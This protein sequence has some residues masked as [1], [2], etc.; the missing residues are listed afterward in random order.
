M[1]K[2]RSK[3]H[4]SKRPQKRSKPSKEKEKT[5]FDFV[6]KHDYVI[7]GDFLYVRPYVFEFKCFFKPRWRDRTIFEVFVDEFRYADREY[8]HA[9]FRDGRILRNGVVIGEDAIW[10][11]S[12]EVL[13]LVHRHESAVLSR[14]IQVAVDRDDFVVVSK[15]PSMPVH[16]CG[17]YRRNSLQFILNAFHGYGRLQCIHRLDKETSGLVILA[18]T[19]EAA[20]QF[21]ESMKAGKVRKTYLAEVHGTFPS[22]GRHCTTPILWDKREMRAMPHDDGLHAETTFKIVSS[23]EQR[24]TSIV[25]C[26][27][28]TGRTHQLRVHLAHLG[29]PIVND[30]IYGNEQSEKEERGNSWYTPCKSLELSNITL[31][32][33]E[34]DDSAVDICARPTTKL[35]EWSEKMERDH[36]RKLTSVEEGKLLKCS[37][38]PQVTNIK[39]VSMNSM[40]IHLHALKYES[41]Q[42][43]F[44]VEKPPWMANQLATGASQ[45]KSGW[46]VCS[47]V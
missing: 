19:S 26:K 15:P 7:L 21:S 32:R 23:D 42:W 41:E 35:N 39:N 36:K 8:W 16:P 27:P 5:D 47:I 24:G 20:A 28:V 25:E 13:H 43:C 1:G 2:R 37:N 33:P 30:P 31:D 38:C 3:S 9:E 4:G 11:D 6:T 12:I 29:F 45:D 40:F 18:K 34:F 17:T 10:T 44:E 46:Q 22:E 14:P